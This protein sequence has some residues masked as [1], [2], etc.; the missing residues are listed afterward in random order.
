MGS[1]IVTGMKLGETEIV[2]RCVGI[3]PASGNQ[4]IYSEDTVTIR[5]M[6]FDKIKVKVPL[7]RLKVG[8]IMPAS[9]WAVPE[10]SSLILGTLNSLKFQWITNQLA[11]GLIA[12]AN[13]FLSSA[14]TFKNPSGI[15]L[16]AF[17]G[18]H[19]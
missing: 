5:V 14:G 7:V 2:G 12:A 9:I 4:I 1:S 3:N 10:I 16:F 15:K 8:A 18:Q 17:S 19:A 6:P 11:D 13:F